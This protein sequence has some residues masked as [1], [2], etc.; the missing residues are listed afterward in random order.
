MS[1]LKL[2]MRLVSGR[3]GPSIPTFTAFFTQLEDFLR[4]LLADHDVERERGTWRL[5]RFAGRPLTFDVEFSE[6]LDPA[7]LERVGLALTTAAGADPTEACTHGLMSDRT[8]AE[9]L[10]LATDLDRDGHIEL[11]LYPPGAARPEHWLKLTHRRAVL[12]WNLLEASDTVP[13]NLEGHVYC[14]Y[15]FA[16]PPWF[17]LYETTLGCLI[18]CEY[19]R[20]MHTQVHCGA[21]HPQTIIHVYG[22]MRYERLTELIRL[23][24][25]EEIEVTDAPALARS[26]EEEEVPDLE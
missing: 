15:P 17:D 11:A 20:W 14:W 16:T 6:P 10:R 12:I 13:G 2:R 4:K 22:M 18:R 1:R 5:H 3:P 8:L 23:F 21:S 9:F 26:V 24:E 7:T 19:P 25:V